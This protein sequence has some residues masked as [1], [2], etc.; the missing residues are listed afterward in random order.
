M[1]ATNGLAVAAGTA[2]GHVADVLEGALTVINLPLLAHPTSLISNMAKEWG[3]RPGCELLRLPPG[4]RP[5]Q[6]LSAHIVVGLF[7][8]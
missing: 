1:Q 4:A 5:Q 8:N 2:W 6:V 7:Q 3:N